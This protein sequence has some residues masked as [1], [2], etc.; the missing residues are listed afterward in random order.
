MRSG[1]SKGVCKKGEMKNLVQLR[2]GESRYQ[3]RGMACNK[4][5]SQRKYAGGADGAWS[6]QSEGLHLGGNDMRI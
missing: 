2:L 3:K 5:D 1:R 6:R 4:H